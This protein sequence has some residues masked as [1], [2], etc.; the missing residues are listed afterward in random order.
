MQDGP[1]VHV[2]SAAA[3]QGPPPSPHAWAEIKAPGPV[4]AAGLEATPRVVAATPR[5]GRV[6]AAA[7]TR[8]RPKSPPTAPVD[9]T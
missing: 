3:L 2:P 5:G 4:G 6:D 7:W 9:F 1:Q 8:R